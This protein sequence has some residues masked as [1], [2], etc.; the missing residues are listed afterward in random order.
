MVINIL[1]LSF[2]IIITFLKAFS[3]SLLPPKSLAK[4]LIQKDFILPL[5][6]NFIFYL[7]PFSFI[8]LI[9]SSILILI[10]INLNFH[11]EFFVVL[12][13]ESFLSIVYHS[14]PSDSSPTLF[15]AFHL[16]HQFLIFSG[17]LLTLIF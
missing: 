17:F 5:I 14:L 8:P 12:I 13:S 10:S 15:L 11:F 3:L 6:K 4:R 7:N 1:L 16:L 9:F 2:L